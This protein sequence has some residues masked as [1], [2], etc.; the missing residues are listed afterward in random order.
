MGIYYLVIYQIDYLC[1]YVMLLGL[2]Y[3]YWLQYYSDLFIKLTT[4]EI[5]APLPM[6]TPNVN[7]LLATQTGPRENTSIA[8]TPLIGVIL[9]LT[10]HTT[11]MSV[12]IHPG[13]TSRTT[14]C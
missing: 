7:V 6:R 13:V 4:I 11:I 3:N 14:P 12:V 5:I 8:E 10:I 9:L 2:Y 1:I